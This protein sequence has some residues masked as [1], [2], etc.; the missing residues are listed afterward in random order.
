MLLLFDA[1]TI[2]V[3][4]RRCILHCLWPSRPPWSTSIMG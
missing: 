2:V 4:R 3:Y 1:Y